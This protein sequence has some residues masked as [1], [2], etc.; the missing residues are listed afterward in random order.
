MFAIRELF[1]A[2]ELGD[3]KNKSFVIQV[4]GCL[5]WAGQHTL[6]SHVRMGGGGML[7]GGVGVS[8]GHC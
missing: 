8:V 6:L 3:I 4:G 7:V 5:G 2:L 1:K